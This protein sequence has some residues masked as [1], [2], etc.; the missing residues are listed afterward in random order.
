[1]I[2]VVGEGNLKVQLNDKYVTSILVLHSTEKFVVVCGCRM[3]L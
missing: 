1:V 2:T 3:D